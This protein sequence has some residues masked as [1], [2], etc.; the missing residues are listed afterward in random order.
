MSKE[1]AAFENVGNSIV[2]STASQM[3]GKRCYKVDGK[4]IVSFLNNHM[5]FKLKGTAH[6]EALSLDGAQL[7]DPA[8]NGRATKEWVQLPYNQVDKWAYF[9]AEALAYFRSLNK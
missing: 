8:G 4:P 9:A 1:E 2:G 3:F 6:Q 5:V 7:F